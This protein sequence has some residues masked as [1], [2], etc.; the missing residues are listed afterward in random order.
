MAAHVP[1]RSSRL[2]RWCKRLLLAAALLLL[3]AATWD[4]ASYDARPWLS[5]YG[6]LKQDMAQGYANLDW[7]AEHRRL[8]LA[9]L[10]RD[11][12]AAIGN[13]H[14]RVRAFLALRRFIRQFNDPHLKLEPGQRP[15]VEAI[16]QAQA[17]DGAA[18]AEPAD[19]PAG[20]SCEAAGYEEGR[21]DFGFAF[22]EVPGWRALHG[23]DFQT[24]VIGDVGVLRIAQFGEDRYLRACTQV[25]KAGIGQRAL[26]LQVRAL[27]QRKLAEALRLLRANGT[28]RLLVDVAGNGGGSE[29]VSE[30]IALMTDR[31]LSRQPARKVAPAC[32]RAGVWRGEPACPVLDAPAAAETLQGT[33][34]WTGPVMILVNRGTASASED[35]VAWL[36]QNRVATV[37]GERTLGAGCGYVDGGNRTQLRA[38]PFDVHMPNCARFLGNGVNE[39]EGIAPDIAIAL[40]ADDAPQKLAL[41]LRAARR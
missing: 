31:S 7:I 16:A 15:E 11:T 22:A 32:D 10:D 25:F 5:D 29:W 34:A 21:H 24:G 3:A 35:F 30:V 41:A 6:R 20:E 38:S 23:G 4:V 39:I 2:Y 17:A 12:T 1:S 36:Q 8:D 19:P 27:Q 9:K 18:T 13:A 26:Q 40:G 37:L 28:T 14:S 33:G